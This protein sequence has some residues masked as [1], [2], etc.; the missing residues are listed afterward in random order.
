MPVYQ[1]DGQHF[2]LP[3][4][5]S[6][7][8]AIAKIK[9]HLGQTEAPSESKPGFLAN[10]GGTLAALG[11][12]G[13]GLIK[14]PL[15]IGAAIGG[16]LRGGS[17]YSIDEMRQAGQA[18][19]EDVLPSMGKTMN[20]EQNP[21]YRATMKPFELMGEGIDYL[22]NRVSELTG[23][24]E[25][26]GAAKL[27]TDI[28]ALGVGIPGAKY[29][30]KGLAKVA[31]TVDPGLRN[32][33]K[34]SVR[35]K[36]DNQMVSPLEA[37]RI[38][39]ALPAEPTGEGINAK[40][41]Y[42]DLARATIPEEPFKPAT[43]WDEQSGYQDIVQ[44]AAEKQAEQARYDAVQQRLNERNVAAEQEARKNA[45]LDINAERYRNR[46]NAPTGATEHAREME[47]A[48]AVEQAQRDSELAQRSQQGQQGNVFEPHTNMHR[49][50]EEVFA[51]EGGQVRPLSFNEFKE[52]LKNLA[53]EPA[54]ST[55][56]N[57]ARKGTGFVMPEDVQAAY[58]QYLEHPAHGQQDFL[59]AH[60]IEAQPSHKTFGEMSPAEKARFTR[61]G[62]Q[63]GISDELMQR[64]KEDE[65]G[66]T[67]FRSGFSKED[68]I[69]A[70]EEI[71]KSGALKGASDQSKQFE[72]A[73]KQQK[74]LPNSPL[75]K[76]PG[77][78]KELR[79]L[80]NSLIES[81][82]EAV[83]LSMNVPDINQN[84]FQKKSNL[85][86]KGGTYMKTRV[87]HPLYD[88]TV[89]H[90]QK[91]FQTGSA[92]V[93]DIVHGTYLPA[94]RALTQPEFEMAFTLL[95]K[96]D[97]TQ[98]PITPEMMD[99]MR[100]T[101][102]LREFIKTHTEAM[103]EALRSINEV[104]EKAGKTPITAREAYSAMNMTG[105]F[106]KVAYKQARDASGALKFDE[107]GK[108]VLDVVGVIGSD[109]ETNP[110]KKLGYERGW[111]L[112]RIEKYMKERDPELIF[113]DVQK[114]GELKKSTHNTPHEAFM[115]VLDVIGKDSPHVK[116]FLNILSEVANSDT[117]NYMGMQKHTL[118]K[119][120]VWGMEGRKPWMS[121][122]EN[123]SAFF[124][125]QTAYLE[126]AL[127][128]S[129]I[130]EGA[131]EVNMALRD[132]AMVAKHP[133]AIALSDKYL[134]KS[135]GMNPESFGK[136]LTEFINKTM[137]HMGVG[138]SLIRGA[139]SAAKVATNTLSFTLSPFFLA[140]NL[141][142]P[143]V[144]T[145]AMV[146]LLHKYGAATHTSLA[147]LG[148][149]DIAKAYTTLFNS[150]FRPEALTNVER[151]AF[152]YAKKNHV[153]AT[154]MI[155][156]ANQV[157][158][159]AGYYA[160]KISQW[161]PAKIETGTR[162][163]VFFTLVHIM[164]ERGIK[165]K[166]GLFEMAHRF[167][168][169]AMGNYS[170][171]ERP[172]LYDN[173]GPLGGLAAN[174]RTFSH[175]ELSRWS[176]FAR[177]AVGN[178][179]MLPLAMQMIM[180]IQVAGLMGLP[181]VDMADKV[182]GEL[183]SLFGKRQDLVIDV[184]K[185]SKDTSNSVSRFFTGTNANPDKHL[186][187]SN[188]VA[189][190]YGANLTPALGLGTVIPTSIPEAVFP[191]GSQITDVIGAAKDAAMQRNETSAKIL[192]YKASPRA[193]RGIEDVAWFQNKQGIT[194]TKDAE[195]FHTTGQ[196]SARDTELR[197][198]GVS[199]LSDIQ[200]NRDYRLNQL[201]IDRAAKRTAAMNIIGQNIFNHKPLDQ[202]A[203]KKYI[204]DG[205]G[206]PQALMQAINQKAIDMNM[207]PATKAKLMEAASRSIPQQYAAQ[208]RAQ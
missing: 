106:R 44:T 132:P 104:R 205:E 130:A 58:K 181:G 27:G 89:D 5:L 71:G 207:S 109:W 102:A 150:K 47:A 131:R 10:T 143:F 125:N 187:L 85:L 24:K 33:T 173:L 153:Y 79:N 144:A 192:A 141:V 151:A 186:M 91:A 161:A 156:H 204:V 35:A 6:N 184:M 115:D 13:S 208:R 128:W 148:Y 197:K 118:Q 147:T 122:D 40:S 37:A 97:A 191:G 178:K 66:L 41:Q 39:E 167:T 195:N 96:A 146:A 86:T 116:E 159:D 78:A 23:S 111:S 135:L 203:I 183:T 99:A 180:T 138:P 48:R 168:D 7:E 114:L 136:D 18:A 155:E 160:T 14:A 34:E 68:L 154:D 145:P 105:D 65:S 38:Q 129:H 64:M 70:A 206:D 165:P 26:G 81:P 158:E 169:E 8:Q 117:A 56:P 32:I 50:Y 200:N 163:Q 30:G 61:T 43:V 157:R 202:G 36:L 149:A 53:E 3:D 140:A 188:G 101:P 11:D 57:P 17:E 25:L 112:E 83:A 127:M 9:A 123:A 94:V 119:K 152:D 142:Q 133:N 54:T 162:A 21:G 73:A 74:Y 196:R 42:A 137:T 199:G 120:G 90:M 84:M 82:E 194:T 76:I 182:Y 108:P 28:A 139:T 16:K 15:A 31:E 55:N 198:W 77:F 201:T 175:N 95:N 110:L 193:L 124:E 63:L 75:N 22:G 113:G 126:S 52:V 51:Q 87:L 121:V 164:S 171:L 93:N 29:V 98:K 170:A 80:G 190:M 20:L 92:V 12:I 1:Y 49:P 60:E 100:L 72:Q 172:A 189:T 2:D 174:L 103:A 62:K 176:M 67:Y 179:N 4:G 69:K 46:E 19:V 88:F 185:L 59:G 45:A 107:K 134:A 166:D 177:E